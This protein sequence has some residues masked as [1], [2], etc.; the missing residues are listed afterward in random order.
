MALQRLMQTAQYITGD[1][2]PNI[3]DLHLRRCERK[4]LKIVIDSNHP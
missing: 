1:E 4:A 3:Q 2:L